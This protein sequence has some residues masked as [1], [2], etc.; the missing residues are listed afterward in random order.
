MEQ[1]ENLMKLFRHECQYA[2]A[3]KQIINEVVIDLVENQSI[4]PVIESILTRLKF[5]LETLK[6][7]NP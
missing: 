2:G 6:K 7:S 3:M 1:Y 5:R 4:D